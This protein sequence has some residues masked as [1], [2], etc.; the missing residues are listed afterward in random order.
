LWSVNGSLDS[1]Y[2]LTSARAKTPAL[3][4][5]HEVTT[6]IKVRQD[7]PLTLSIVKQINRKNSSPIGLQVDYVLYLLAVACIR[8]QYFE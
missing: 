2:R 4:Q 3:R 6:A 1:L 8:S 5:K 7:Q